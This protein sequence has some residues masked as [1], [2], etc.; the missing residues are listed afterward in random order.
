MKYTL[1]DYFETVSCKMVTIKLGNLDIFEHNFVIG[2][3]KI[4]YMY[5]N[6]VHDTVLCG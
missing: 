3:T 4:E 5:N 6:F 2:D 1:Y